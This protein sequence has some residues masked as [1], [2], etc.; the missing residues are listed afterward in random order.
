MRA[1][2]GEHRPDF[3]ARKLLAMPYI[4]RLIEG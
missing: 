1:A 2:A 4:D 3:M